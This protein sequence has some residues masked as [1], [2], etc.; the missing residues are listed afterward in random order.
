MPGAVVD[1]AAAPGCIM[2]GAVSIAGGGL[3][4]AGAVSGGASG[5]SSCTCKS[6]EPGSLVCNGSSS[7][8]AVQRQTAQSVSVALSGAGCD[9]GTES[10]RNVVTRFTEN[11]VWAAGLLS[12]SSACTVMA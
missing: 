3:G 8:A 4:G 5:R 1:G 10:S 2:L 12:H 11:D 6:V 7:W 9:C